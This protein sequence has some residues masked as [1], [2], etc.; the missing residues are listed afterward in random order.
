[1]RLEQHQ[2]A[3]R[4]I[5]TDR[6]WQ[7]GEGPQAGEGQLGT[8]IWLAVLAVIAMILWQVVPARI[9][10]AQFED[11]IVDVTRISRPGTTEKSI[12]KQIMDKAKE[13]DIPLDPKMLDVEKSRNNIKIRAEYT[14]FLS[15]PG[16]T[17]EMHKVH[18]ENRPVFDV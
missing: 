14:L 12:R 13:Y 2:A 4:Q 6:V 7:A 8:L 17:Y 10:I 3:R 16:Y 11:S 1:M 9:Q 18:D 15:F 5:R